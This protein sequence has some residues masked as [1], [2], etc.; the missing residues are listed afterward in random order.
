MNRT[1]AVVKFW[2]DIAA[3]H[4]RSAQAGRECLSWDEWGEFFE[5]AQ[6]Y[7]WPT[8]S[9]VLLGLWRL[10]KR[11]RQ[12][13]DA[14]MSAQEFHEQESLSADVEAAEARVAGERDR[15]ALARRKKMAYKT[16]QRRSSAEG[17]FE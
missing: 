17:V 8:T 5:L 9:P 16:E 7:E 10:D 15:K 4:E 13:K 14:G 6:R 12:A 3:L 2:S 1:F 11:I